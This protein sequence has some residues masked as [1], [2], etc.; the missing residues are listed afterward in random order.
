VRN[1]RENAKMVEV[2][3]FTKSETGSRGSRSVPSDTKCEVGI[4][5]G[6]SD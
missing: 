1:A 4:V 2:K 6:C 3:I 5:E